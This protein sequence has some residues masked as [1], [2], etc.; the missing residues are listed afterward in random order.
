MG[1]QQGRREKKT[2]SITGIYPVHLLLRNSE[3]TGKHAVGGIRCKEISGCF[4]VCIFSLRTSPWAFR[5]I[6]CSG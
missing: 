5:V 4:A 3:H 2:I 6:S 1:Y